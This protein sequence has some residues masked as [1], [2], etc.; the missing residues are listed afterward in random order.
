MVG[1]KLQFGRMKVWSNFIS[2]NSHNTRIV[3]ENIEM[4]DKIANALGGFSNG[5]DGGKIDRHKL[6]IGVRTDR[7]DGINDR[8]NSDEVTT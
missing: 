5:G 3:D 2:W 1:S 8:L 7:F 6:D 4:R